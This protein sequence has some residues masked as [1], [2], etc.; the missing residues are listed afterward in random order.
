MTEILTGIAVISGITA[1]LAF[2]LESASSVIADYGEKH[3]IVNDHND[4]IVAGGSPLLSSLMAKKIF[5]PSACGGKGT[6]S[7]CKVRVLEGGGP[8]LPTELPIL[9]GDEIRDNVRLSCQVKVREDMKIEIP[10]DLFLAKEYRACVRK[11]ERLSHDNKGVTLRIVSPEEGIDFLPGQYIQLEVPPSRLSRGPEFRAYSISSSAR[12]RQNIQL[13]VTLVEGGIVSTYVHSH[14]KEGE[15]VVV[16]GPFG[17]FYLRE[18]DRDILFVATGSG[19][20]PIM[21]ILHQIEEEGIQRKTTLIFGDRRPH[22]L[23]FQDQLNAWAGSLKNFTYI[24]TLTRLTEED[25]WEGE[26]GRVT[27]MINKYIPDNYAV[28]AYIC[29]MPAMV[30]SCIDL[31]ARKGIKE[32][33]VFF[34]E[35]E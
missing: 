8:L 9:D 32:P 13:V 20:A 5:V 26:T 34:D 19:L 33:N 24:P 30:E 28:D 16:R 25:T 14:L 31:L 22:D 3:I 35:F 18:S 7:F 6:C 21:S 17:D 2:I 15:Y 1:V 12:D 11:I 10:E 23:Y 4:L 29:G 27:E